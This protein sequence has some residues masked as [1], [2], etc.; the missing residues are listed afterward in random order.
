MFTNNL[1]IITTK[2]IK[3]ISFVFRAIISF[4]FGAITSFVFGIITD[5]VFVIINLLCNYNREYLL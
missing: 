1:D 2:S 4:V 3:A 5:C